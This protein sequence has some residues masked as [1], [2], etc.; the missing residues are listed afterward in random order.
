MEYF[1]RTKT[2]T[3]VIQIRDKD[4]SRCITLK[5]CTLDE[6]YNKIQKFLIKTSKCPTPKQTC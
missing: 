2:K 5:D 6:V 4:K 3:V 1:E